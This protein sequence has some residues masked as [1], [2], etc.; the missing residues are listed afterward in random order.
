MLLIWTWWYWR[1]INSLS[2]TN[3]VSKILWTYA[4]IEKSFHILRFLILYL[5]PS[6]LLKAGPFPWGLWRALQFPR[7][8]SQY[9]SIPSGEAQSFG[10]FPDIRTEVLYHKPTGG[11]NIISSLPWKFRKQK[12]RRNRKPRRLKNKILPLLILILDKIEL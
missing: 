10:A 3:Q 7:H 4:N 5:L 9:H 2:K 8:R 1:L 12:R 11:F 6:L